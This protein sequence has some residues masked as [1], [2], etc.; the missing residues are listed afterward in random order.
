MHRSFSFALLA[1]AALSA[2]LPAGVVGQVKLEEALPHL[3][4]ETPLQL[5]NDGTSNRLYVVERTGRIRAAEIDTSVQ[6]STLFLDLTDRAITDMGDDESGVIGLAFHPDYA[7]NGYFYVFYTPNDEPYRL[8]LSRFE[9][10][11]DN[12]DVGDPATEHEMLEV[13]LAAARHH[14]G[15]LVF[16]PDGY[17]YISLGDDSPGFDAND[18][19]RDLTTLPGSLLRI[20]VDTTDEGLEYGIPDDNPFAGNQEGYREEIYAYGLRQPWQF[21]FDRDTGDIWVGDVGQDAFEEI[22]VVSPGKEHGWPILEGFECLHGGCTPDPDFIA[23]VWAY[24]HT[25]TSEISGRPNQCIIGGYVYRGT[26]IPDLV[27]T[28]VYADWA[29]GVFWGLTH[30]G[31]NP[32]SNEMLLDLGKFPAAFGEDVDGELYVIGYFQ[33]KVERFVRSG[34]TDVE[35]PADPAELRLDLAGPNPFGQST[36]LEF[37]TDR[38]GA[39]RLTVYD[40]LG[41]EVQVAFDGQVAPNSPQQVTLD[42]TDLAPGLYMCLLESDGRTQVQ[43]IVRVN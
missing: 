19:A 10:S 35:E 30:D 33:G 32:P 11:A 40:M 25:I 26:A 5:V 38:A 36:T 13:E 7:D 18:N 42:G 39:V 15:D 21:S 17:L 2:I 31:E 34:T 24:P 20:D 8:V 12:P 28:Y 1:L 27:G 37:E 22:T 14:G 9:R 23:P 29:G 4:F 16:G 43:R 41:R 3:T 6:A